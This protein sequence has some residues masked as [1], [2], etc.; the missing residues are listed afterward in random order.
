MDAG[1]AAHRERREQLGDAFRARPVR[2][3]VLGDDRDSSAAD[4][5]VG[6]GAGVA[7]ADLQRAVAGRHAFLELAVERTVGEVEPRRVPGVLVQ[8][9]EQQRGSPPA[10]DKPGLGELSGRR[11]RLR[12]PASAQRSAKPP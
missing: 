9:H 11:G 4:R 12:P 1:A 3:Q 7:V 5:E 8:P 10:A 2:G 6:Q